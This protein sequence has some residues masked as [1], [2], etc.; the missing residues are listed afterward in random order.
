MSIDTLNATPEEIEKAVLA[1][2][3]RVASGEET[4][5]RRW[6]GVTADERKRITAYPT[7]VSMKRFSTE[8]AVKRL[9][10]NYGKPETERLLEEWGEYGAK[11]FL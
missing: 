5:G 3:K 9:L 2:R 10:T 11:V 4:G 7:F 8:R 6:Q 1:Y